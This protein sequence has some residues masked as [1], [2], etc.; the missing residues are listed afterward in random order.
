[1]KEIQVYL[2]RHEVGAVMHALKQLARWETA[3]HGGCRNLAVFPVQGSLRTIGDQDQHYS[4]V[5][6]ESVTD[7][8][9]IELICDDE[10]TAGLIDII[11]T[12][13]A[14]GRNKSG[15]IFVS[16]IDRGISIS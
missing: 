16:S 7:E 10:E 9:K 6:S 3:E 8:Y 12:A 13:A 2:H 14:T 5:L 15:W 11:R 4:M 1:M